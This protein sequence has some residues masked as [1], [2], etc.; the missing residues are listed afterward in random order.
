MTQSATADSILY[1][2]TEDWY[3]W[4]HRRDLALAAKRAGYHV[5]VATREGEFAERIRARGFE[6]IPVRMRRAG[7][8]IIS[9]LAAISDLVQIYRRLRP[10]IVHHIAMKP[11][12]YGAIAA[13][14]A[15]VNHVVSTVAGLG[16]LFVHS[17]Y[18]IILILEFYL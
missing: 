8:G 17:Y 1:L 11:V 6:L 7:S 15:G 5:I 10:S 16:Y 12:V 18:K 13:R 2:V 9:E 14:I 4:S 3:F